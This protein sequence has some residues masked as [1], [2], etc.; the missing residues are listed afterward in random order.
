MSKTIAGKV[1][2]IKSNVAFVVRDRFHIIVRVKSLFIT[3][4]GKNN[5]F[6]NL[7]NNYFT[8][9]MINRGGFGRAENPD[10]LYIKNRKPMMAK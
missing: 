7:T 3:S 1:S 9:R 10:G 6:F 2:C 8:S 4:S 5:P